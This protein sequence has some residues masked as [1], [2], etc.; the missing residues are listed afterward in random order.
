[1]AIPS[2]SGTE[3]LKCAGGVRSNNAATIFTVGTGKI[4]TVLS[5]VCWASQSSSSTLEIKVNDGSTD[6]IL[7]RQVIPGT[8]TFVF[9]DKIVLHPT[10]ILK[11]E[12]TANYNMNY[13]VSWIEQ[14]FGA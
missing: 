13:W 12:E 6:Y 7:L 4:H 3:V 1:M 5:I 8:E 2:G 10:H 11:I 14:D 9:N